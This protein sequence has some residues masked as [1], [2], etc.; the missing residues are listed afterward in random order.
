[1]LSLT[2]YTEALIAYEGTQR[3]ETYSVP[4]NAL[5]EAVTNFIVHSGICCRGRGK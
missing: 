2:K 1:M 4:E 3:V 5:R